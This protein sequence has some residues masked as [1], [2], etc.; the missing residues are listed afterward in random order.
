M[1]VNCVDLRKGG[2]FRLGLRSLG[3]EESHVVHGTYHEVVPPQKL[4]FSFIV[5]GEEKS[6]VEE[7]VAITFEDFHGDT[8]MELTHDKIRK[9]GPVTSR[10][11]GWEANVANLSQFLRPNRA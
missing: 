1:D 8:R 3:G 5:E 6:E 2:A 4:V 10:L 9:G 7:L 11:R